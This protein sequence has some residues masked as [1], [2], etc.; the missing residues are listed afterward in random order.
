MVTCLY[1]PGC[2]SQKC[3]QTPK[4]NPQIIATVKAMVPTTKI[5]DTAQTITSAAPSF[6]WNSEMQWWK[7]KNSLI[8]VIHSLLRHYN[9]LCCQDMDSLTFFLCCF[10]LSVELPVRENIV[11]SYLVTR[12]YPMLYLMDQ[13]VKYDIND[14][15]VL[16]LPSLVWTLVLRMKTQ[17]TN[18]EIHAV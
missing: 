17:I 15:P 2:K 16:F 4:N 5:T 18:R 10:Q 9:M 12:K 7:R 11:Q 3:I 14:S 8:H 13:Y 6:F 1:A